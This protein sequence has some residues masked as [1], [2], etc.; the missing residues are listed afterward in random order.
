MHS[1]PH[2]L[3][4]I[5]LGLSSGLQQPGHGIQSRPDPFGIHPYSAHF[6]HGFR[7]SPSIV[8]DI[9][10]QRLLI[11]LK[12]STIAIVPP[13][14]VMT[15]IV[16]GTLCQHGS[17]LFA[18]TLCRFGSLSSDGTLYQHGSFSS[19]DTLSL[20]NSLLFIGTLCSIGSLAH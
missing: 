17:L 8:G 16:L 14:Q 4:F 18:G 10:R 5:G 13:A 12:S 9:S 15:L 11:S 20:N 19:I 1:V 3:F 2:Y 7:F 6:V